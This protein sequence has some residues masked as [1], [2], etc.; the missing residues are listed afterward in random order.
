[1]IGGATVLTADWYDRQFR[2][3]MGEY[4]SKDTEMLRKLPGVQVVAPVRRLKDE[5]LQYGTRKRKKSQLTFVDQNFW[6]TQSATVLEGRLIH[7][8]D[9][10]GMRKVCV[11]GKDIR[12]ELFKRQNP[13]GQKLTVNGY[14]YEV[15]GSLGGIQTDDISKSVFIPLSLAHHHLSGQRQLVLQFIRVDNPANVESVKIQAK[16]ILTFCHPDYAKGIRVLPQ[17]YRLDRLRFVTFLVKFFI[18]AALIGIFLLGKIGLTNIMLAT[19]QERTR[20]IGLR[21]AV[22]ASDEIIL[23]QFIL[24]AVFVG[25]AAGIIGTGIGIL[26]IYLLRFPLDIEIS[27]YVMSLSIWFD[28]SLTLAIGIAAGFYPA[29]QASRL[30]VVTAMRFE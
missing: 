23:A 13:V 20:E 24:E 25:F 1:M 7:E 2:Y 12:N 29:L 14:V 21:K 17:T 27:Y 11:V 19:V 9:V 15:V 28:I 22:G 4:Y 5:E 6:L 16:E 8:A 26:S 30:D 18:Y 3:H 10:K